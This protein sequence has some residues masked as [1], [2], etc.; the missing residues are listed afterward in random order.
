MIKELLN[1]I[2]QDTQW[3]D[4]LKE[5]LNNKNINKF[6]MGFPNEWETDSVWDN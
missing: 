3:L 1:I 5:L 4:E 6:Q 2:H